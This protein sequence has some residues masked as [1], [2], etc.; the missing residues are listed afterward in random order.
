MIYLLSGQLTKSRANL[1]FQAYVLVCERLTTRIRSINLETKFRSYEFPYGQVGAGDRG[2]LNLD[3]FGTSGADSLGQV[4]RL[5]PNFSIRDIRVV[6]LAHKG[7]AAPSTPLIFQPVFW[8]TM[9]RFSRCWRRTS[10]A[11]QDYR[12]GSSSRKGNGRSPDEPR[13][14]LD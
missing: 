5:T 12:V 10:A 13:V 2:V 9:K 6:G 7:S 1:L 8:S 4:G 11:D 3:D 14:R